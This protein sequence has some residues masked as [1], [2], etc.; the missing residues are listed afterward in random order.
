VLSERAKK[1]VQPLLQA[2]YKNN[3]DGFYIHAP[4]RSKTHVKG[5]LGVEKQNNPA[6]KCHS[7]PAVF[8]KKM[9]QLSDRIC[10]FQHV[11]QFR[12]A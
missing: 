7:I 4:K 12:P 9:G 1:Q 3:P 8:F 6:S 10:L 5:L 2:A 11:C